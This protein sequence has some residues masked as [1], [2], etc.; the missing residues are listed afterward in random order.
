M[1][2]ELISVII[3]TAGKGNYFWSCLDSIEKQAYPSIEIAVIDNSLNQEFSR[4]IIQ[5]YPRLKVYVSQKNIFYCEAVNKGL[6]MARGDFILCLND[7]VILDKRFVTS[8]PNLTVAP[9]TW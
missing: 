8:P 6:K 7:D 5:H 3:V 1:L 9:R 2:N 4:I